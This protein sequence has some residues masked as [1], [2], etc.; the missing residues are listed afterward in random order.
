LVR[1]VHFEQ[2]ANLGLVLQFYIASCIPDIAARLTLPTS[3]FP[4]DMKAAECCRLPI[5]SP[6]EG[7]EVCFAQIF[8]HP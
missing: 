2:C 3:L 6:N 4:D 7:Q 8:F 5:S 1:E